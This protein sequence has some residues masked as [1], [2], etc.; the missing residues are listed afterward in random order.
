MMRLRSQDEILDESVRKQIIDEIEGAENQRRRSQGFKWHEIWKNKSKQFVREL[1]ALQL[2]LTTVR[3]MEYALSNISIAKKIVDKLARVYVNGVTRK[4]EGKE[5]DTKRLGLLETKLEANLHMKTVNKLLKLRKN[6]VMYIKPVR[7]EDKDGKEVWRPSWV[8]MADYLYDVVEMENDRT[9]AMVFVL[10]NFDRTGLSLGLP[11]ARAPELAATHRIQT[12][13]FKG[14]GKDQKIADNKEDEG[15]GEE[16]KVYVWWSDKFHFTT[17]GSEIV[18]PATMEPPILDRGKTIDDFILNPIEEK[19]FV[20]LHIDQE[21]RY[22]AEG[23][24]DLID[25]DLLIN[26]LL[27]NAH[28]IG[29]TQG[30]GQLV[31]TGKNLPQTVKLGPNKVILLPTDAEGEKSTAEYL[32]S[33]PPLDALA[34]QVEMYL[35]LLLTTN[36]LSTAG[37]A[38][39]L[40]G[41]ITA[42]SGIALTIDKAESLEDVQDQREIFLKAEVKAFRITAKWLQFFAEENILAEEFS[43]CRIPVEVAPVTEFGDAPMIFSEKEK[44]ENIRLREELGINRRVELIMKD[45][46]IDEVE[47]EKVL[48]AIEKEKLERMLKMRGQIRPD[49]NAEDQDSSDEDDDNNDE[50]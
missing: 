34:K 35:A 19:T 10:S 37:V 15:K 43:E 45:R 21:G 32:S 12:T 8:P 39:S 5:E 29:V 24:E 33:S 28:H 22:W 46:G 36:N 25:G 18:D 13:S 6:A 4:F 42:P 44:L 31:L 9:K 11:G 40:Q 23:G 38:A 27:S 17:L 41:G 30:F 16:K 7:M 49:E 1:L 26:S 14:D 3:E 20:D 2:D 48:L 47:A 50:A